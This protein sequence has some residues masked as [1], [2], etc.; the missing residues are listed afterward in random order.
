MCQNVLKCVFF[1]I[2]NVAHESSVFARTSQ[3]T[4]LSL[5]I[6]VLITNPLEYNSART[7]ILWNTILRERTLLK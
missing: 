5:R 1:K 3:Q 2:K 6:I 4:V 7:Y